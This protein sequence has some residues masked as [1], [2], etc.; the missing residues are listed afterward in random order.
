MSILGTGVKHISIVH[1][2][3]GEIEESTNT[4]II[5]V[6]PLHSNTIKYWSLDKVKVQKKSHKYFGWKFLLKVKAF[7]VHLFVMDLPRNIIEHW[8]I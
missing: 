1:K 4:A 6:S 2:Y 5:V 7:Y 8:M 3:S